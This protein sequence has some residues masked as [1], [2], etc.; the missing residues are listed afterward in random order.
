MR[1]Q[2][3]WVAILLIWLPSMVFAEFYQYTDENGVIHYTDNLS[4]VPKDQRKNMI[5]YGDPS[6]ETI[7]EA[8]GMNAEVPDKENSVPKNTEAISKI[9]IVILKGSQA[10]NLLNIKAELDL[11]YSALIRDR[12]ALYSQVNTPFD[13]DGSEAYREKVNQFNE[14]KADYEKRV[15]EFQKMVDAYHKQQSKEAEAASKAEMEK[16]SMAENLVKTKA[17]LDKEYAEL[18][19]ERE[20]I[21]SAGSAPDIFSTTETFEAYKKKVA[22]F[23]A[24]RADYEKRAKDYQEKAERFNKQ[25]TK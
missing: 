1:L 11:E 12:N 9:D 2:Y 23:N 14:R 19:K 17:E 10:D 20:A 22:D 4:E 21:V 5:Q 16:A 24:R 25:Q 15:E 7:L 13:K 8:P 6:E 18:M 3:T